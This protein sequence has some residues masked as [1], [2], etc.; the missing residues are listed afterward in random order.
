[1]NEKIILLTLLQNNTHIG[2]QYRVMEIVC[3]VLCIRVLF[4]F[5]QKIKKHSD[6]DYN[7]ILLLPVMTNSK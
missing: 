2:N 6:Y 7:L 4:T 1:M 3:I 5:V